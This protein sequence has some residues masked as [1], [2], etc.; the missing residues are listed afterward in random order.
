MAARPTQNVTLPRDT[1]VSAAVPPDYGEQVESV[2]NSLTSPSVS[3]LYL[4][5]SQ[6]APRESAER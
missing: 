6:P 4:K 1:E 2:T 5:S 3:V